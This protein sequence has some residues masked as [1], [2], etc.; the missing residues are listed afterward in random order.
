[1]GVV[2][3]TIHFARQ[4][5]E[6]QR[7]ISF[8]KPAQHPF[9]SH[10]LRTLA[11]GYRLSALPEIRL[12]NGGGSPCVTGGRKP[13]M[14]LPQ[15][16]LKTCTAEQLRLA[17]A[18]ELAHLERGDLLWNGFVAACR[19]ALFFHPLVWWGA[20]RQLAAQELACDER[21]LGRTGSSPAVLAGMLLQGIETSAATSCASAAAMIGAGSTV[22]ERI[23]AMSRE[24]GSPAP[25]TAALFTLAAALLL[26]PF[27]LAEQGESESPSSSSTKKVETKS[28]GQKSFSGGA[29]SGS[30]SASGGGGGRTFSSATAEARA[31]TS[32]DGQGK[33]EKPATESP[34]DSVNPPAKKSGSST[35]SRVQQKM[36]STNDGSGEKWTRTTTAEENGREITIEESEGHIRVVIKNMETGKEVVTEAKNA[37]ELLKKS[38]AA[39][40]VYRRY[41]GPKGTVKAAVGA[42]QGGAAAGGGAIGKAGGAADGDG[43]I[44]LGE[45]GLP[46]LPDGLKAPDAKALLKEQLR[47]LRNNAE[48][49]G[50]PLEE[51]LE[52]VERE[53]DAE[54]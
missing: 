15:A 47:E 31:I 25:A 3:G 30:A 52:Q 27:S 37:E 26:A 5:R 53:V 38:A 51:L 4:W 43:G 41:V 24:F 13:I 9:L 18:H 44:N 39:H 17:I 42:G 14:L 48:V 6:V 34:G 49:R 40:G 54:K 23:V 46:N 8:A 2:A 20:R 11:A 33:T 22:R 7:R 50:T 12:L 1:L 35:S 45:F 10:Q 32:G 19:V 36:T 21:A 16:W 29:A 28:G